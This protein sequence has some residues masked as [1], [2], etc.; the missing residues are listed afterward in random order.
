MIPMR[1]L[2]P[3]SPRMLPPRTGLRGRHPLVQ[4]IALS[5]HSALVLCR[6]DA[7]SEVTPH[8]SVRV[9]A[10]VIRNHGVLPVEACL[11]KNPPCAGLTAACSTGHCMPGNTRPLVPLQ[12]NIQLPMQQEV[13]SRAVATLACTDPEARIALRHHRW[14]FDRLMGVQFLHLWYNVIARRSASFGSGKPWSCFA[15][16]CAVRH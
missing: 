11:A 9:H 3:P 12:P 5:M 2:C 16:L 14:N 1:S 8:K 13:I 15:S 4:G 7:I 6:Y 10:V